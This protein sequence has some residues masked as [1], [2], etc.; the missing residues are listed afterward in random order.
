MSKAIK[1]GSGDTEAQFEV[2]KALA[3]LAPAFSAERMIKHIEFL[4]SPE[5]KGRGLGTAEL[6]LAADYIAGKFEEYGLIPA[7]DKNSFF[8]YFEHTFHSGEKYGIKNV[9]AMIPGSNKDLPEPVVLSAHY[10]H[11]GLGWPDVRKGNEGK[12]HFGADDNASGVAVL[13]E[14]AKSM[15]ESFKPSRPII[16]AAFS[17]EEAGLVG[18]KYFVDNFKSDSSQKFLANLNFDTVGR[19]FENKIMILNGNTA[20]EWKFIF[21]GTEYTTGIPSELVMQDLD[22]SDQVSFIR[23]GVPAVQF[24]SGPNED[25]HKPEDVTEKI[26]R[27]GLIKIAAVGKEVVQ[28]LAE[29]ADPMG[30]T[31]KSGPDSEK[32]SG[33]APSDSQRRVSTGIMPDF[34]Y[35]GEGVKVASVS[36]DSPGARAGLLKGDVIKKFNGKDIKSLREYSDLL[37]QH[38]PGDKVTMEIDREGELLILEMILSER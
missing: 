14:L 32:S 4:A 2:R 29:R 37:K 26:D 7:G 30:F 22:A 34:A 10:D 15:G 12:I 11:L 27:E 13:L 25:Y 19:L 3:E 5:M 35:S 1:S 23:T 16:F 24:F 20:R 31:G 21:M 28:Y 9:L 33:S 36:D 8:Q 38:S 18:S 17:G 6:D